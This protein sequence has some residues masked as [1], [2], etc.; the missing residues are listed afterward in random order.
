[1]GR[2]WKECAWNNV[3]DDKDNGMIKVS[4]YTNRA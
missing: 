2:N 4:D 3:H 1:M